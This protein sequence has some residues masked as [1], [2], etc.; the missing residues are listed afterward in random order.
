MTIAGR[1]KP[2]G[3]TSAGGMGEVIECTDLHLKRKVVVKRLQVGIS[4]RRLLDEQK[5]LAKLRSKHVVQLYD[6]VEL[7]DRQRKEKAIVIE[8]IEGQ[9]LQVG[10]F[11]AGL[12]YLKVLWQIACGLRDIH[13][14]GVIHRDIKPANIRLDTEG[15]IKIIDFGLARSRAEAQTRGAVG[16]PIYM[17]PELWGQNTVGFDQAIDVYAFGVTAVALLTS[18]VP[19]ERRVNRRQNQHC[20][21]YRP[22]WR[23]SRQTSS[24]PFMLASEMTARSVQR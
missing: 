6:I 23:A 22:L 4:E 8:Y 11:Q 17:A 5:A 3:G 1:Y 12:H 13:A 18:S 9:N 21:R 19:A 15:V 2:T 24:L 20:K 16:T 10:S 7:V 14:A